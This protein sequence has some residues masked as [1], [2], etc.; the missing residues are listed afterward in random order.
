MTEHITVQP[1]TVHPMPVSEEGENPEIIKKEARTLVD[2]LKRATFLRK[3]FPDEQYR[4]FAKAQL[5]L[6]KTELEFQT[7]A[8]IIAKNGQIQYMRDQVDAIVSVKG[9]EIRAWQE[10]EIR[11]LVA[12]REKEV[13]EFIDGF[14]A[15]YTKSKTKADALPDGRFKELEQERVERVMEDTFKHLDYFKDQFDKALH[16][17]A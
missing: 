8:L 17:A 2:E 5:V 3:M 15:E 14:I 12:T 6:V 1:K 16:F 11:N 9:V 13:N 7:K 4:E 10:K